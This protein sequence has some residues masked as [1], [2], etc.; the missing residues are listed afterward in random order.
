MNCCCKT[1]TNI[2]ECFLITGLL[3][4]RQLQVG[5]P[6]IDHGEWESSH[7]IKWRRPAFKLT[8]AEPGSDVAAE[9]AAALAASAVLFSSSG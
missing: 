6:A 1:R 8:E 4:A 9:T 5:D 2:L 7:N 3:F